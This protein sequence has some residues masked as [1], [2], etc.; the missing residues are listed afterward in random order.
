MSW[1]EIISEHDAGGELG[2]VYSRLADER[3][4][5]SDIMR[6]QSLK[7][8]AMAAHLDLYLAVM[9]DDSGLTREERELMAVTVSVVNT[10]PYCITHHVEAL[11]TY[12][13]DDRRVDAFVENPVLFDD[14]DDRQRALVDYALQITKKP[15]S[16]AEATIDGLREMGLNDEEILC[17]NLVISYFNFVNRIALGLGVDASDGDV[18]GYE[19]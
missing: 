3:G 14:L 4:K 9:F 16:A 2:E 7:P 11:R 10:C 15:S 13:R 19:Y 6:S 1:I 18:E 12:W 17:A 8:E 5:V